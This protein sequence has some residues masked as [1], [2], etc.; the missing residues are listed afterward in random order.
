M[1]IETRM[2]AY[3]DS[4]VVGGDGSPTF[5]V[6]GDSIVQGG[7]AGP[8]GMW[9][10]PANGQRNWY[11]WMH[12]LSQGK[13]GLVQG[14]CQGTPGYTSSQILAVH[15]P[16]VLALNPKPGYCILCA[17]INDARSTLSDL[18]LSISNV[19]SMVA[20]LHANGIRPVMA[21]FT[22]LD[23]GY[24]SGYGPTRMNQWIARYAQDQG[25]PLIDFF[26]LLANPNSPGYYLNAGDTIDGLHPTA[27]AA[28]KMGQ[29]CVDVIQ[30]LLPGAVAIAPTAW[31]NTTNVT[32]DNLIGTNAHFMSDTAGTPTGWTLTGTGATSACAT[33]STV[34]GKYV[35][36]TRGSTDAALQLTTPFTLT[37]GQRIMFAF[38][39]KAVVE[40]SGGS[41]DCFLATF[42][43]SWTAVGF[44]D[45]NK[46]VPG[47]SVFALEFD[48]PT[49][50]V[51]GATTDLYVMWIRAKVASGAQV[52]V[53]QVNIN[54]ETALGIAS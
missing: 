9:A 8:P 13:M 30:E 22:P 15:L 21:T 1:P 29:L 47:G 41:V 40:A 38:K 14:G 53:G 5:A 31:T 18:A 6:L 2:G 10:E 24:M 20:S 23:P 44:Q 42:D 48:V 17:C 45:I 27:A 4:S 16:Q 52:S 50:A 54:D 19:K 32:T 11:L 28:K 7:Y 25:Y 33:D 12:I 36:L 3:V 26:G 37:P 51:S 39:M 49:H 43:G 34:K 46:D 35:T